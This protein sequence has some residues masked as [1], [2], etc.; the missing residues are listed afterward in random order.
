[1]GLSRKVS[2]SSASPLFGFF[3]EK[4][5]RMLSYLHIKADII[6]KIF[7]WKLGLTAST[8]IKKSIGAAC[9]AIKD[10]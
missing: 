2:I 5:N 8:A 3:L 10:I 9:L 7:L 1:M 6:R 4:P